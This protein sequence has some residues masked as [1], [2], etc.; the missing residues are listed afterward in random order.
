MSRCAT[1]TVEER[2]KAFYQRTAGLKYRLRLSR[3]VDRYVALKT[4]AA[5]VLRGAD[6]THY[7]RLQTKNLGD[8]T[9][10]QVVG[11]C[12]K[13]KGFRIA[14]LP[15]D[16][17]TIKKGKFG[18][19]VGGGGIFGP[20]VQGHVENAGHPV[21]IVGVDVFG[22][23]SGFPMN[24]IHA[25]ARSQHGVERLQSFGCATPRYAPDVAWACPAAWPDECTHRT[26]VRGSKKKLG[27]NVTAWPKPIHF[28]MLAAGST[29]IENRDEDEYTT[30]LNYARCVYEL[31]LRHCDE[32]WD[33]EVVPFELDDE[34]LAKFLFKDTKVSVRR[35]SLDVPNMLLHMQEYDKFIATRYHSH[36][37]AML[38]G[39]PVYSVAYGRNCEQLWAD[40]HWPSDC[41]A[42]RD[43]FSSNWRRIFDHWSTGTGF[44][45]LLPERDRLQADAQNSI[46]EAAASLKRAFQGPMNSEVRS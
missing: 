18:T 39:V 27:I 5:L 26:A 44:K 30:L 10:G 40:N 24:I 7:Y 17:V 34:Y 9:I 21:S 29:T 45:L 37:F 8:W 31:A 13:Q 4:R 43:E 14:A 41:Q 28:R 12:L 11:A 20:T 1:A 15:V 22:Q 25:S 23:G 42:A 32:G 46:A 3:A 33:V 16:D 19:I 36:I 38:A 6:I 2:L 35:L